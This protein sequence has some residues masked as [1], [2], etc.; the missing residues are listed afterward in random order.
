K[1]IATPG[2][3]I[4]DIGGRLL[5]LANLKTVLENPEFS[6]TFFNVEGERTQTFIG[7]N[8]LSDLH[9]YLSQV[10]NKKELANSPF[11]YL[12][13]D[14][15]AKGSFLINKIFNP[16][17]GSRIRGSEKYLKYGYV[18]GTINSQTGKR[19]ASSKQT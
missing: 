16:N 13:T 18:G 2:K 8:P 11:A 10:K 3:K 17:T 4:L 7:T 5:K 1:K 19:K 15:F 9:S 6:S 12:L 14:N